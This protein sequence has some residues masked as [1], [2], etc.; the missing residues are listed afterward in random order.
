MANIK[1]PSPKQDITDVAAVL[2]KITKS[3]DRMSGMYAYTDSDGYLTCI[4]YVKIN[5]YGYRFF[6]IHDAQK[7]VPTIKVL[8]RDQSMTHKPADLGNVDVTDI[9]YE[10]TLDELTADSSAVVRLLGLMHISSKND[11]ISRKVDVAKMTG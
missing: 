11:P 2:Q 9:D 6:T 8:S 5:D 7:D 4:C 1:N 3:R 10:L